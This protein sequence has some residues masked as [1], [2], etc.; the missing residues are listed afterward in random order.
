MENPRLTTL[1][2]N[3]EIT[4]D[5]LR[6]DLLLAVVLTICTS[7]WG[8]LIGSG[9]LRDDYLFSVIT[10][11]A[12]VMP[13]ALRRRAPLLMISL[14]GIA[15]LIQFMVVTSPTWAL[16]VIPL[17]I[18]SVARWVEKNSRWALII[19]VAIAGIG[20][21]RWASQDP[22]ATNFSQLIPIFAPLA[23]LCTGWVF[24]PYLLGRRDRENAFAESERT[25]N[26]I[27]RYEAEIA[28]REEKAR[29]AETKTRNEIARELHDI[30]AH[31]LSVII[32]QAN[33]GKALAKK[34][35]EAALDVLDT[36]SSTG[37]EA[38]T[39]MRRLVGVLRSDPHDP[40]DYRPSPGIEEMRAMLTSFGDRVELIVDGQR[41]HMSQVVQ[42]TIYRIVQ[43]ALTN[44]V[45]HA[46]PEARGS[47]VINYTNPHMVDVKIINL[48][49]DDPQA[50]S[51]HIP[52]GGYGITGMQER[53][54][55]LGGKLIA[56]PSRQGGWIV[57]AQIPLVAE[58]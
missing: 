15:A 42:L 22:C 13:L 39:E 16:V 30:V 51:L 26:A 8:D 21:Y 50:P 29:M 37:Q 32:V 9:P 52:S 5:T 25:R 10:C 3:D 48:P 56:Q 44:I 18:H 45:K 34:R 1:V 55:A 28:H 11:I 46:G 7:V 27:A 20:P 57:H 38:L 41:P 6:S 33:G 43:E 17:G 36:I 23:L 24:I 49:S 35:P 53:V 47:V 58:R 12:I 4:S 14:M 31:S 54:L 2:K 40:V 19:G